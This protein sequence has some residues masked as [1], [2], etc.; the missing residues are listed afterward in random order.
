VDATGIVARVARAIEMQRL[1]AVLIGNAAAALHGAP[2]TTI[3]LDFIIRRTPANKKKLQAVAK[4]LGA[5]LYQP[6][7]PAS[8]VIRMMNDDET[9]QVDFMEEVSGIRSFEGIRKRACPVTVGS[10][11]VRVAALADI[12]K[13]KRA[14]NRPRDLAV[15]EILEKTLEAISANAQGTAGATQSPKRVAGER[16]DPPPR[17]S[18]H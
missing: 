3:D 10:A 5:T 16:H 11:T 7:Y 18:A 8:R 6:F 4:A 13:S 1:E 12:I 17:R 14:A 9:L 15:L 2:V